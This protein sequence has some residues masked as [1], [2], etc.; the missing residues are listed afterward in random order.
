[1]YTSG[2][3]WYCYCCCCCH[4]LGHQLPHPDLLVHASQL[5]YNN[6]HTAMVIVI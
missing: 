5:R 3:W 4:E 6:L 2:C 1:M